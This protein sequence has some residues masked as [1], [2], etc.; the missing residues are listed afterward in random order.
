[1]HEQLPGQGEQPGVVA[2]DLDDWPRAVGADELLQSLCIGRIEQGG[3]QQ[4]PQGTGVAKQLGALRPFGDGLPVQR[5]EAEV[6]DAEA[7]V[8]GPGQ[9]DLPRFAARGHHPQLR[10]GARQGEHQVAPQHQAPG[11]VR[12][13]GGGIAD[14]PEQG[15]GGP[16][17]IP[18]GGVDGLGGLEDEGRIHRIDPH[19]QQA[20]E[21][22]VAG[23]PAGPRLHD[24]GA[25]GRVVGEQE[26]QVAAVCQGI[27]QADDPVVARID[28]QGVHEDPQ[29]QG[30]EPVGEGEEP[31][32]V[33]GGVGEKEV[34]FTVG[35]AALGDGPGGSWGVRHGLP[36]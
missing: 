31:G 23:H 5:G 12:A 25:A 30:G 15:R 21:G 2:A 1:V 3:E 8:L 34:V 22:A 10:V 36:S 28:C 6:G 17:G 19:R 18:V 14:H 35:R 29:P 9:G 26:H 20:P 13:Q 11:I 4:L 27:V 24:P 7:P 32:L 16:L 33:R